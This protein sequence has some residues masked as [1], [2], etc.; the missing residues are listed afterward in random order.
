[1][2]IFTFIIPATAGWILLQN[3][4]V[5]CFPVEEARKSKKT[6]DHIPD[7]VVPGEIRRELFL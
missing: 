4:E 1:M 3:D 2:N 6:N 5:A 7:N